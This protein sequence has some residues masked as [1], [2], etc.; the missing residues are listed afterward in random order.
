MSKTN[1]KFIFVTTLITIWIS[2]ITFGVNLTKANKISFDN[3]LYFSK[4]IVSLLQI[5]EKDY[6][7]KYVSRGE[8]INKI[9]NAFDLKTT[10]SDY[11]KDCISRAD[12]CFFVFTAMSSYDD[13]SFEPLRLYPDVH[14]NHRYY[15]D[16][17]MASMLGLAHGFLYEKNTPF[18]PDVT[19][20]RI[21]FIKI[22]FSASELLF[23]KEK[24][25]IEEENYQNIPFK[26]I[27]LNDP[28]MWWYPRY[29]EFALNTGIV[30][31]DEYFRPDDPITLQELAE[32]VEKTIRY[33]ENLSNDK[34]ILS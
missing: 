11:L 31:E 27:N 7:T 2:Q 26:D 4:N 22:L 29:I 17:N 28:L 5:R 33:K 8:A 21:Q 32:I 12:E 24:F 30:D 15:E 16:I 1:I 6:P 34:K 9:I 10:K 19:I 25:E 18:K 3:E 13:I 14:S 23:W 20:T